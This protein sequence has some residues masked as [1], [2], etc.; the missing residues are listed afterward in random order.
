MNIS[1]CINGQELFPWQTPTE[2][3]YYAYNNATGLTH[4]ERDLNVINL[5]RP[6]II[7]NFGPKQLNGKDKRNQYLINKY[8]KE[9]EQLTDKIIE[10][11][12]FIRKFSD[13]S[14]RLV[15]VV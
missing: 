2:I 1:L 13:N 12:N 7:E 10:I 11:K 5:L 6:W 14:K 3:S 8:N 9:L 15:Q 4:R